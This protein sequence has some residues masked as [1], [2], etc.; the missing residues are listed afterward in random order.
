[1]THSCVKISFDKLVLGGSWVFNYGQR[2][3]L[4]NGVLRRPVSVWRT[5]IKRSWGEFV[6]HAMAPDYGSVSKPA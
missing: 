2:N 5:I 6:S 4:A 3:F 1:M